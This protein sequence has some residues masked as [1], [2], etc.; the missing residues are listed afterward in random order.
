MRNGGPTLEHYLRMTQFFLT[1]H[2]TVT[3]GS[4]MLSRLTG[5]ETFLGIH[6]DL[7]V[8]QAIPNLSGYLINTWT[9]SG[10]NRGHAVAY[11]NGHWILSSMTK[12]V[13]PKNKL[14]FL[15][16]PK[17]VLFSIDCTTP[18]GSNRSVEFF[19]FEKDYFWLYVGGNIL[20]DNLLMVLIGPI[21]M[22]GGIASPAS[23]NR[24]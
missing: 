8:A 4:L 6:M 17:K 16:L 18:N 23:S 24:Y 2:I 13:V 20:F 21:G 3:T 5:V 19:K 12:I 22:G 1:R 10:D 9:T 15:N 14:K 7:K 11:G